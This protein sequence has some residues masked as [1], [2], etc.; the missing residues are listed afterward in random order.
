M[1]LKKTRAYD[2]ST[3]ADAAEQTR[4]SILNVMGDLWLEY[5]L[6]EI[7]LERIAARAGVTERTILRKFGSKDG[8][9]EAAIEQDAAG[10]RSEKDETEAGNVEHAVRSLMKEYTRT[11]QAA[12]RTLAIEHEIPIAAK[13][14]AQGRKVHK[15]WCER[16]FA[17]FLPGKKHPAYKPIIGALYAAT[18][19]HNWKLLHIDLGYSEKDTAAIFTRLIR[20]IL[21][22]VKMEL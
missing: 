22:D 5:P 7:T 9:F 16:V 10:I 19:V 11:G 21:N 20:A 13:M 2:M 4:Q 15:A 1:K 17:P 6:H 14:L 8:L 12:M 3:R 18:D